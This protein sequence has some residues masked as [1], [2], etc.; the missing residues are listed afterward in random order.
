MPFNHAEMRQLLC[1]S[2]ALLLGAVGCRAEA[3]VAGTVFAEVTGHAPAANV[4]II[5]DG[6]ERAALTRRDGSFVLYNVSAGVHLL[7][8]QAPALVYPTAKVQVPE[9]GSEI[10]VLEY[11]YPGAPR[12]MI[13]HPLE[14]RPVARALVYEDKQQSS[15]LS[16]LMSPM[17]LIMAAT[18]GMT[19]CLPALQK[20]A[21]PD[22]SAARELQDSGGLASLLGGLA[23]M[24]APPRPAGAGAAGRAVRDEAGDGSGT[25]PAAAGSAGGQAAAA[26]GAAAGGAER[27]GRDKFR[28]A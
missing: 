25:S 7:E 15:A 1:L 2:A 16:F 14:L 10:K 12:M 5:M 9:D 11:K 3:D 28:R 20:M 4:R 26:A 24:P 18:L 13:S 23:G 27:R 22:G 21:D 6:G 19:Y 17:V 8:L